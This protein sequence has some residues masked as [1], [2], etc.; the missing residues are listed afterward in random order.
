VGQIQRPTAGPDYIIKTDAAPLRQAPLVLAALAILI[1]IE[2]HS[3]GR[4]LPR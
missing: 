1:D 3:R 2:L 4:S